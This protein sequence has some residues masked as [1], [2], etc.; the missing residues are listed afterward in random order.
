MTFSNSINW[1]RR[2]GPRWENLGITY[3]GGTFT[4][5]QAN[6]SALSTLNCG[7]VTI[8]STNTPGKQNVYRINANQSFQ[9]S[10]G[11]SN[12]AGNTWGVSTGVGVAYAQDI[13][14]FIYAV[15]NGAASS[16]ETTVV[17][18]ISRIPH[19][20]ISPVAAKLAKQGSAVASTQGSMYL[21][22]NP[23]VADYAS[24]NCI[25]IGAFRMQATANIADW[26]VQTLSKGTLTDPAKGPDGIGCFHDRSKFVIPFQSFGAAASSYFSAGGGTIPTWA[27]FAAASAGFYIAQDGFVEYNIVL[28]N[29]NNTPAGANAMTLALPFAANDAEGDGAGFWSNNAGNLFV[30][31]A[32][33]AGTNGFVVRLVSDTVGVLIAQNQSVTTTNMSVQ[34]GLR[35][36]AQLS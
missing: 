10:A 24:S 36:R 18:A 23:T 26:T 4:V 3:S 19:L 14:F 21:M 25:C 27:N 31:L 15:E 28:G 29:P 17:F 12:L 1:L 13:P 30:N 34:M 8:P 16:P 5:T 20:T 9:D 2:D 6:A 32:G 22:N 7:F 11:T 35:Y 33:N